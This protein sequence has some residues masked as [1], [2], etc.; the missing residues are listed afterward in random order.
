MPSI[1]SFRSRFKQCDGR[2]L[3][4]K[5][6]FLDSSQL[7]YS[8]TL[9][10]TIANCGLATVLFWQKKCVKKINCYWEMKVSQFINC[11]LFFVVI[12][13]IYWDT[14]T[15]VWV[16]MNNT[17]KW[18]FYDHFWPFFANCMVILHKTEVQM[19]ILMW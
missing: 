3:Q 16:K 11:K 6:H 9:I 14:F 1:W 19:V 8:Q 12:H 10:Q 4:M 18:L 2:Y 5:T 17:G 7:I 13:E 15:I